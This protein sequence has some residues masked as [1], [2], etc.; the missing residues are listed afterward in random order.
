MAIRALLTVIGVLF[1]ANSTQLA[2]KLTPL[3]HVVAIVNEKV[4]TKSELTNQIKMAKEEIL[5]NNQSLPSDETLTKQVL[6]QLIIQSL[7]LQLAQR[8]GISIDEA[9]VDETIQN[10]AESNKMTVSQ[11]KDIIGQQGIDFSLYR[12]R[13]KNEKTIS[14]LQQRDLFPEL[15]VSD[16]EIKQFMNAPHS[17]GALT[18]EYRLGHILVSVPGTPTPEQLKKAE[19]KANSIVAQL[20]N[21][22]EFKDIAIKES[23][24]RAA[25][26]GG[27]LGWRKLPEL[28]QLF[29]HRVSSMK[30][31]DI[32]EPIRSASGYH[33][34]KLIEK[35]RAK[36][37]EHNI[38]KTSVRHILIKNNALASES[39]AQ[40][41][42]NELK[43]KIQQGEDFAQIAK[44]YSEDIGSASKGG[45][46][47]WVT[48]DVLV[49]EFAQ[50]MNESEINKIS[51]PFA[52]PFGWHILQVVE[53][54][55][56]DNGEEYMRNTARRMIIQRKF[57]E[58]LGSWQRQ[59][60]DEAYVKIL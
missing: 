59:M 34:I 16:Q 32:A 20:K 50:V 22:A 42:L 12:Q 40:Q 27:D 17:M 55:E 2:A 43:F 53:R 29:E 10:I 14:Q 35:R 56:E 9:A 47:G 60:R 18:T 15:Q 7:Q 24:D 11:L 1:L 31:D 38:K 23:S 51:E 36:A 48:E 30:K 49:P 6:E 57:E 3:D 28:P 26:N 4:I 13:L 46:L 33:I 25:L 45:S 39:E 58:K 41:K 5:H 19:E 8:T 52:S 21:G 44:A 37:P 54:A